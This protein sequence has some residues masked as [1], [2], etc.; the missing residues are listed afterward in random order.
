MP[1]EFASLPNIWQ[2]IGGLATGAAV[3]VAWIFGKRFGTTTELDALSAGE[4]ARIR[5][6]V[7][8]ILGAVREA[9]LLRIE[10]GEKTLREEHRELEARLRRIEEAAAVI[11]DRLTRLD[12]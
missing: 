10:Q 12:K 11:K 2:I 8:Q 1:D 5:V 6:D 4:M 7:E 3:A 9:M